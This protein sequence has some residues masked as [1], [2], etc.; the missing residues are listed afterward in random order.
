MKK[1]RII[2][3]LVLSL[4]LLTSVNIISMS[5]EG[6]DDPLVTLSYVEKRIDD[7]REYIKNEL[8]TVEPTTAPAASY[9][10]VGPDDGAS[11]GATIY[12]T[13]ESTEF[14]LRGG[15]ATAIASTNGG[16]ADLT[17]GVDLQTGDKVPANHQILIARDDGRGIKLLQDSWLM[18]KGD[19][20]IK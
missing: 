2:I 10:I 6:E 19:Y 20:V 4:I 5:A 17:Q 3:V 7:V 11:K 8:A 12:F 16:L 15:Q 13:Q 14:I 1:N 18:I 9:T